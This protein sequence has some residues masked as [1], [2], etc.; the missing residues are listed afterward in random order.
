[1]RLPL[2]AGQCAAEGLQ[3]LAQLPLGV[4]LCL[5]GRARPALL[6]PLAGLSELLAGLVSCPCTAWGV[7]AWA[8][9]RA[10]MAL[11]ERLRRIAR[12]ASLELS[13]EGEGDAPSR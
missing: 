3:G 11:Q 12:Q 9:S 10:A 2:G 6:Q 5:R 1:L 7:C 8:C 13:P 4:L